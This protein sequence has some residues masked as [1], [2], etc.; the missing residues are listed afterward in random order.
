[1]TFKAI[2][3]KIKINVPKA[4]NRAHAIFLDRIYNMNYTFFPI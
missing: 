3:N 4:I 2:N 1:M